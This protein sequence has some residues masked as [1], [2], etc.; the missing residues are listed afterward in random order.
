MVAM[1]K[2]IL[3]VSLNY[4]NQDGV[5]INSNFKRYSFRTNI[6]HRI[7]KRFKVG[8]SI[9]GSYSINSGIT[10]GSTSVGDGAV[11]TGSILGAAIG[12][13]PV[14]KPYRADGTLFPFGE[15][16][17]GRYRE[18]S[19]P[20]GF[21]QTLNQTDLRRTLANFYGEIEILKNLTYS[22]ASGT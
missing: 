11:V 19:N 9:L 14:L 21:A 8:T 16:E 15:Q 7:S 3:A 2:P 18:V 12:A 6:D 10:T 4:F 20:L 13:P 1:K 5:I 17:D 22:A